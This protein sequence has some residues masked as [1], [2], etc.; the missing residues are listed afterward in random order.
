MIE[1]KS[2]KNIKETLKK[3]KPRKKKEKLNNV[4]NIKLKIKI[5]LSWNFN[6]P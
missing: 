3:E 4:N 5:P 6:L 2:N 1:K